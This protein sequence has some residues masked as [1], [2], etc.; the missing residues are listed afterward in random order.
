M[1]LSS[2]Y[3]GYLISHIP[4]GLLAERYSAK[5]TLSLAILSLSICTIATPLSIHYYGISALIVLRI[6]MGL[7][8]GTTF[9][10]LTALL[11]I[12]VPPHEKSILS[13]L[14]LGGGQVRFAVSNSQIVWNFI[15]LVCFLFSDWECFVLLHI[16]TDFVEMV[17]ASCIL[18][19]GNYID[20]LVHSIRKFL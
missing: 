11:A 14:A 12:W 1:I 2:F 13:S 17:M 19:L 9:P 15:F 20:R 6:L 7:A 10:A 18:F 3:W 5:W 16:R 4:G 8:S